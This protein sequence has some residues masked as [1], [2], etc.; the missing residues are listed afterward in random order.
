MSDSA[1][2]ASRFAVSIAQTKALVASWLDEKPSSNYPADILKANGSVHGSLRRGSVRGREDSKAQGEEEDAGSTGRR[3]SA[4]SQSRGEAAQQDHQPGD[5]SRTGDKR[6]GSRDDV[7]GQLL[8]TEERAQEV[9]ENEDEGM[10]GEL[11][12]SKKYTVIVG[13]CVF[14]HIFVT[15]IKRVGLTFNL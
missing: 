13:R 4:G 12:F 6:K 11:H 15:I 1:L 7:I 14:I 10:S 5:I 8:G 9:L 3:F 2:L